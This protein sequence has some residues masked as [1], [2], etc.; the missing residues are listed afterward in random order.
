MSG[1]VAQGLRMLRARWRL[2]SPRTQAAGKALAIVLL[3]AVLALLVFGGPLVTRLWPASESA[4]LRERAAQALREGRLSAADGTGARELYEAALALQPDQV[5]AR[6]GLARVAQAA[7]AR[8]EAALAQGDLAHAQAS[9]RIARELDAP[10][11]RVQ[12]L[13]RALRDRES[14]LAGIDALLD[15]AD[16]ARRAGRLD[17]DA[18]AAL[19]LYARVLAAQPRNQRAVEGREDALTDLLQPGAAALAR[20]DAAALS[21]LLW[22]AERF[23]PGHGELPDLRAGLARL[24]DARHASLQQHVFA[25]RYERAAEACLELRGLQGAG[26]WP[27]ACAGVVVAGLV[28]R[29]D[30]ALAGSDYSAAAQVTGLARALAGDDARIQAVERRLAAARRG[31]SSVRAPGRDGAAASRV[32]RLLDEAA[33]AQARGDWLTPPGES[34]WDKLREAR[35]LAP[36]A[37]AVQAAWRGLEPSARRCHVAALRDNRLGE[38]AACL[39]VWRQLDPDDADLPQARSRLAQRWSA[40][41][42]E[43]LGAGEVAA[44]QRA[45]EQARALDPRAPGVAELSQRLARAQ[46]ARP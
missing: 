8:S 35:A 28:A 19:P 7:L 21:L 11:P 30:A 4:A 26:E 16:A 46:A 18:D 42:E 15:Q 12:A 14:G 31:A 34:A 32:A 1:V 6:N 17:E 24:L 39:D 20:G 40:V 10:R 22:R 45:L 38:A 36:E 43:R 37:A 29:A 2:A 3:L 9:L 33:R 27:D 5:E 44:A 23:D 13:E 25:R 41:G